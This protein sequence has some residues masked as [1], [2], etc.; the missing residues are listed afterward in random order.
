[1]T[2]TDGAYDYF[3]GAGLERNRDEDGDNVEIEPNNKGYEDGPGVTATFGYPWGID[4]DAAGILYVT[5][6]YSGRIRRIANTGTVS[7]ISCAV[8]TKGLGNAVLAHPKA[9]AVT[10]DGRTLY[11][12]TDVGTEVNTAIKKITL[13]Y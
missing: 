6:Y 5:E 9:I 11:V 2:T 12:S 7:T 3:A 10:A 13:T 1:V 8:E 4:A